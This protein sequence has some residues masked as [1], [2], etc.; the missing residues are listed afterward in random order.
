[1]IRPI[2]PIYFFLGVDPLLRE[3]LL[4]EL[5]ELDLDEYIDPV[6]LPLESRNWVRPAVDWLEPVER[7]LESRN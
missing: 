1:M 7:P 4:V 2:R 5:C 3:F 6:D